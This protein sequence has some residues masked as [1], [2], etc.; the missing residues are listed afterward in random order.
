MRHAWLTEQTLAVHT[1]S[2]GTYGAPRVGEGH[3][4]IQPRVGFAE[5]QNFTQQP[6]VRTA[7]DRRTY[8]AEGYFHTVERTISLA[9]LLLELILSAVPPSLVKPIPEHLRTTAVDDIEAI[10]KQGMPE[11]DSA[12]SESRTAQRNPDH[13]RC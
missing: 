2:R 6:S 13:M 3:W 4:I 12:A 10:G 9:H 8:G 11:V 5:I 1:A 7:V